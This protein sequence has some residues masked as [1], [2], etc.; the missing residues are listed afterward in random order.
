[1]KQKAEVMTNDSYGIFLAHKTENYRTVNVPSPIIFVATLSGHR[2]FA[3]IL[4]CGK[5]F[6]KLIVLRN[7]AFANF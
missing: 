4:I 6:E 3:E 2:K 1:L 5:L 7:V